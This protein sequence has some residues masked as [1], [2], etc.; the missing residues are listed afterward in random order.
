MRD[1]AAHSIYDQGV[2]GEPTRTSQVECSSAIAANLERA[3]HQYATD[4]AKLRA[5]VEAVTVHQAPRSA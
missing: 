2:V 3:M 4:A 1:S 5:I